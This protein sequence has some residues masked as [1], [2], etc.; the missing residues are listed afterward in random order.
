MN[1]GMGYPTIVAMVSNKKK[2]SI[3]R[4]AWSQEN[5][6]SYINALAS[7][8]EHFYDIR[9]LPTKLK[10]IEPY[11]PKAQPKVETDL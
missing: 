9:E 1:L 11:N 7:N 5:L 6:A 2:F 8:Q 10:T 4:R 3:M